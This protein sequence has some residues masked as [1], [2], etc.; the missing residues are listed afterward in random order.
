MASGDSRASR[1]RS[2]FKCFEPTPRERELTLRFPLTQHQ[3]VAGLW[4]LDA[5][6]FGAFNLAFS[7][8]LAFNVAITV[9]LGG[10]VMVALGYLLAE[11]L[12]R[13]LAVLALASGAP[14][15]AP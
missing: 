3:L 10:L 9:V 5:V 11:R 8:Q 14:S 13:P 7:A 6:V 12:L 4:V 1:S 2:A 15:R